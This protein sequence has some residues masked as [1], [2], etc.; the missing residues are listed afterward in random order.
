MSQDNPITNNDNLQAALDL[1][2]AGI[3]IFPARAENKR[4]HVKEWQTV[5]T[6]ESAQIRRWWK[7]WPDAMPATPTGRRNGVAVLDIDLKDGKN[8]GAAS[9]KTR[10]E[11]ALLKM[12]AERN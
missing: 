9:Q 2:K 12:T 6:I 11:S 4:P 10:A 3:A 1:A 8:G 5:A 7:K